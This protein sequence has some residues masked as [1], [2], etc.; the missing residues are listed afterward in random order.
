MVDLKAISAPTK[1]PLFDE[2][3]RKG[4]DQ[5]H[6]FFLIDKSA[7]SVAR[8]SAIDKKYVSL[9][10]FNIQEHENWFSASNEINRC[11]SKF[12]SSASK[13]NIGITDTLYTLIP[14]AL[15]DDQKLEAY[16]S[17][18][19]PKEEIEKFNIQYDTIENLQLVIV[20]GIPK[21]I[22][23]IAENKFS[24]VN[25]NHFSKA[26]LETASLQHK[27]GKKVQ[28]HIQSN[29][30]D[31]LLLNDGELSFFNS[32]PYKSVE[33]FIYYLLYVMEQLDLDRNEQQLELVGEFEKDSALYETLYKYIRNVSIGG[34]STDVNFS[35]ILS[36]L[37]KQYYFNL[38]NQHLCG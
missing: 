4:I 6:Q 7:L 15:F 18:N 17:L 8:F 9:E 30:F 32:F 3:Y 26:L 31:V 33:D 10:S 16:L 12:P 24:I 23:E 21:A 22:K 19:H 35:E 14:K 28:L 1:L 13:V 2:S 34:R 29:R 20:Y 25:W 38:F 36:E 37:P 5:L 11:F 27:K